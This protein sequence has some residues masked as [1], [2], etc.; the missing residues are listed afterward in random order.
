[1]TYVAGYKIERC[2]RYLATEGVDPEAENRLVQSAFWSAVRF[3]L[4]GE[5]RTAVELRLA[6]NPLDRTVTAALLLFDTGGSAPAPC[7]L[8]ERLLPHDYRWSRL[9][10]HP[11]CVPGH[12]GWPTGGPWHVARLIRRIQFFNLPDVQPWSFQPSTATDELPD[13]DAVQSISASGHPL[14]AQRSLPWVT[15]QAGARQR[16]LGT[17]CVPLLHGVSEPAPDRRRFC[18]ELQ[19]AAPAILSI[20]LRPAD[21]S[22]LAADRARANY[23]RR[24]LDPLRGDVHQAD[25]VTL[26]SLLPNLERYWM[27]A[28]LLCQLTIR[29][30]S[31]ERTRAQTVALHL[32]A[33]L[34]GLRSFEVLTLEHPLDSLESLLTGG[35][36][37]HRARHESWLRSAGVI[38]DP[39]YAEFLQRMPHLYTLDEAERILQLPFGVGD[40]TVPGLS[41]GQESPFHGSS[42]HFVPVWTH[43]NQPTSPPAERVRLGVAPLGPLTPTDST[44]VPPTDLQWHTLAVDDLTKHALITGSTG[45]GKTVTTT[46]LLQELARLDVGFLII[47]PA[48][49]EYFDTLWPHLPH[50]RRWKLEGDP[51]G[52]AGRDFLVFDPLRLQRGVTVA[53]HLSYLRSCFCAAFPLDEVQSLILDNG[54]RAYYTQPPDHGGCGL[55]LLTRGGAHCHVVRPSPHGEP[56]VYPSWRTFVR[57]MLERYL[58]R[59]LN[60]RQLEQPPDFVWAM[61]QAFRRRFERLDSGVF[62]LATRRADEAF[63]A[64]R[65]FWDPFYTLLRRPTVVELDAVADNED[66]AL[67]MAFLLTFLYERRQADDLLRRESGSP[68][69]PGRRLQ[70]VLVVEEAHRLLANPAARTAELAGENARTRAVNLFVD[71]LAEIR[72]YGQGLVIVEQIPTKIVPEAIKNT[73]LKMMLRMASSEDRTYL[74]EAMNLNVAQQRFTTSLQPGQCVVFEESVEEPLFLSV[75]APEHWSRFGVVAPLPSPAIATAQPSSS[76]GEPAT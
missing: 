68:P 9:P 64:R 49:T 75:P 60:P 76:P 11:S 5:Q 16:R 74:G 55:S 26:R 1:M 33:Q 3:L 54:L 41:T 36:R 25:S 7:E 2:P 12:F 43:S 56:L 13:S 50:L 23:L 73:N 29:V 35:D 18:Q 63:L 24:W 46:L 20:V 10:L 37:A 30:A 34:G 4:S 39:L 47:E 15:R 14:S 44:P 17:L 59:E 70:H 45:S 42:P 71:M 57:F 8:L 32:A 67:L 65:D 22:L 52:Q 40:A 53:R 27:P 6:S 72:A 21:E 62:G 51:A 69:S 28:D 61:Q 48:K 38:P 31:H 19:H 58:D 66:K